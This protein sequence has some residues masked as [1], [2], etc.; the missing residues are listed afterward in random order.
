MQCCFIAG[1]TITLALS[2]ASRCTDSAPTFAFAKLADRFQAVA[3]PPA[4]DSRQDRVS[5]GQTFTSPVEFEEPAHL[6]VAPPRPM[7]FR[8]TAFGAEEP[9]GVA[10]SG[11]TIDRIDSGS[12]KETSYASTM[13]G[14]FP[15]LTLVNCSEISQSRRDT[16]SSRAWGMTREGPTPPVRSPR[17]IGP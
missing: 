5:R 10:A 17:P 9:Y 11:G 6:L 15:K 1:Q 8:A 12:A 13:P 16:V 3:H 4:R 14:A 2:T 7:V